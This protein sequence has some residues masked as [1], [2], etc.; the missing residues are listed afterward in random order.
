MLGLTNVE[1]G[2]SQPMTAQFDEG[3]REAIYFF[4]AKDTELVLSMG[5]RHRAVCISPRKATTSSQRYTG[6]S[7]WR[8]IVRGS[9]GCGIAPSLPGSRAAKRI[10]HFRS[11][12]SNPSGTHLAERP[13]RVRRRET[14]A[15]RGPEAELPGKTA[16]VN[17]N[18]R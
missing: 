5:A 2:E 13:E 11:C 18:A 15:Q 10:R 7:A 9:T 17:L 1:E 4:T 12:G 8:T 16:D 6:S 3:A 14:V